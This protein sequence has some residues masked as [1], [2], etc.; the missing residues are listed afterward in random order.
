MIYPPPAVSVWF[1]CFAYGARPALFLQHCVAL[2]R[3]YPILSFQIVFGFIRA[4]GFSVFY[5]VIFLPL[6]GVCV[7]PFSILNAVLTPILK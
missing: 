6:A 2:G 7:H 4:N 1:F 5:A 3:A